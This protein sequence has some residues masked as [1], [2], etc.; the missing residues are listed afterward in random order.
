M[1]FSFTSRIATLSING[2]RRRD[3]ERQALKEMLV[4]RWSDWKAHLDSS[5]ECLIRSYRLDAPILQGNL[6]P[7]TRLYSLCSFPGSS[8]KPGRS[9]AILCTSHFAAVARV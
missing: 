5:I 8:T 6:K 7:I 3:M 4:V 9:Q 2:L 1:N